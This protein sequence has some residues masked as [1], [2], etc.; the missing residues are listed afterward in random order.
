M[1]DRAFDALVV[2]LRGADLPRVWSLLVTVFG[3]L[4]QDGAAIPAAVLGQIVAPIGVRPEAMRVALHRL[5][6]DGWID[7]QRSGRTSLYR[8]S[9]QGRAQTV[10]ASP[11]I[12]ASE[13]PARE[14]WLVLTDPA[15]PQPGAESDLWLTPHMRLSSGSPAGAEAFATR[16][17]PDAPLPGWMTARV[18]DAGV[19]ALSADLETRLFRLQDR[20]PA[21]LTATQAAILRVLI[22]HGWR[23]I[24]LKTPQLPDHVFP[25][26][27]QG[28][29]CRARV[30]TLLE[31]LPRHSPEALSLAA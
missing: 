15:A 18:C 11:R 8:L 3:D 30:A 14:A 31:R 12:Y 24:V 10:A 5:K 27:W 6:K 7:S 23:R 2:D 1:E 28:P 17:D 9:A 19:V 4:A 20:L 29:A 26:A 22:V 25:A 21:D 16:L 13:P